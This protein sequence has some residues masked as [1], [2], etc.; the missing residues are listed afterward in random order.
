MELSI[1]KI[2]K[3]QPTRRFVV[4]TEESYNE[5][6]I[7][8]G[9]TNRGLIAIDPNKVPKTPEEEKEFLNNLKEKYDFALGS[10]EQAGSPGWFTVIAYPKGEAVVAETAHTEAAEVTDNVEHDA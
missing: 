8:A 1:S 4:V 3:D 7:A 9:G 6:G 10:D 5:D 2:R